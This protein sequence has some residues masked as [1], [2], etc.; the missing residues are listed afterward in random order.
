MKQESDIKS[1][2]L[3]NKS[4][5]RIHVRSVSD[6]VRVTRIHV[7]SEKCVCVSTAEQR[8]ECQDGQSHQGSIQHC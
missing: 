2:S 6:D 1:E 3:M 5:T 7:R 8:T 4:V